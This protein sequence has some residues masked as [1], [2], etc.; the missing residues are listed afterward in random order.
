MVDESIDGPQLNRKKTSSLGRA[1]ATLSLISFLAL[2]TQSD[3]QLYTP[4]S[5]R[6]NLKRYISELVCPHLIAQPLLPNETVSKNLAFL[7]YDPEKQKEHL[8]LSNGDK[9]TGHRGKNKDKPL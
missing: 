3:K 4:N 8:M 1:F 6:Y 5:L 7:L 2:F 9:L